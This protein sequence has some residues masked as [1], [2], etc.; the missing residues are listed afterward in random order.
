MAYAEFSHVQNRFARHHLS[1][2]TPVSQS[3]VDDII[4]DIAGEIDGVLVNLGYSVPVTEPTWFLN[5]LRSLNAD[6]AASITLKSL[7]P[8]SSGPG[9]TSA[10]A[11]YDLR[12]RNGLKAL[13]NGAHPK[14]ADLLA[15]STYF[16]KNAVADDLEDVD[17][18]DITAFRVQRQY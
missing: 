8:E 3:Q 14:K 5:R 1:S 6:G 7:F 4:D 18:E 11:F 16:T 15:A 17:V 9:S 2:S 10:Y 13:K 12:Y